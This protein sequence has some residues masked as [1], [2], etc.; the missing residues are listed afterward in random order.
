MSDYYCETCGVQIGPHG[1]CGCPELRPGQAFSAWQ[2][3]RQAQNDERI[4]ELRERAEK[5]E[6]SARNFCGAHIGKRHSPCPV[7]RIAE[8][9]EELKAAQSVRAMT[10]ARLGGTVEGRPTH[11]GNFLQRIDELRAIEKKERGWHSMVKDEMKELGLDWHDYGGIV[12][13]DLK[14][15]IRELKVKNKR[16]RG[17]RRSARRG[18]LLEAEGRDD[19]CTDCADVLHRMAEKKKKKSSNEH[20]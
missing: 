1:E 9:E 17:D 6:F 5:A 11:S 16:L 18:A 3:A 8:L 13:G 12:P 14:A 2:D 7:C 10:V 15:L 4:A 20:H 19:I